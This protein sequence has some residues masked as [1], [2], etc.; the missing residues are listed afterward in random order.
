MTTPHRLVVVFALAA[1]SALPA[2]AQDVSMSIRSAIGCGP[3]AATTPAPSDAP[4][5]VGPQD[6]SP[7]TLYG[8]RDLVVVDAGTS[9]GVQLGQQFFVRRHATSYGS[10]ALGPHA[11][12]TAGWTRVVAVNDSTAIAMIDFAC[13][14]ILQGDYLDPYA[15][16]VIPSDANRTDTGGEL[17]FAAPARVLFGD[18]GR[19]TGGAGDLMV[20]DVGQSQGAT[21][22]ARFAVYRDLHVAG[23]P[24]VAVGE[25]I[26]VSVGDDTSLV[27][28]TRTRDAVETGDLLI[29]RK[30]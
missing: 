16:P 20:A 4:R 5:I 3:Q 23:V 30:R 14:G 6:T 24:L 12:I 29:P 17:D 18:Y 28:L 22:G 25:A 1:A 19:R 13:D 9:R 2:A 11:V 10:A 27:R 8:L 26:V 7:R 21:P 15:A